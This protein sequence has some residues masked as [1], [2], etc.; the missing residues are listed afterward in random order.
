MVWIFASVVLYL[1]VVVPGWY[2]KLGIVL[3][4]LVIAFFVV[5]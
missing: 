2:R 4:A 5:V 1:V 3:L